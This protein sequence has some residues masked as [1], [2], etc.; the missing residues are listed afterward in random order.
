MAVDRTLIEEFDKFT[1]NARHSKEDKIREAAENIFQVWEASW[2]LSREK[3][4]LPMYKKVYDAA[5]GLT[6]Q[7]D[8]NSPVNKYREKLFDSTIDLRKKLET[9]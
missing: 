4:E 2:I 9:D 7:L 3:A 6:L 1:N 8:W 5:L